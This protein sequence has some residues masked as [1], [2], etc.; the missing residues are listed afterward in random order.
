MLRNEKQR[1]PDLRKK[2]NKQKSNT[3]SPKKT[4]PTKQPKKPTKKPHRQANNK[5]HFK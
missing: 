5:N 4:Q 1:I 3:L 2:N